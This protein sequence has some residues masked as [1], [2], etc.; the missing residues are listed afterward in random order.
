MCT[1]FWLRW[2]YYAWLEFNI[3]SEFLFLS[4]YF[5]NGSLC[6]PFFT[7]VCMCVCMFFFLFP[8]YLLSIVVAFFINSCFFSIFFFFLSIYPSHMCTKATIGY[9]RSSVTFRKSTLLIMR[10]ELINT[11]I[12]DYLILSLSVSPSLSIQL[13]LLYSTCNWNQTSCCSRERGKIN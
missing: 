11:Y 1:C 6:I 9:V 7:C 3:N 10:L 4:H 12:L 2:C 8:T 13:V 5:T